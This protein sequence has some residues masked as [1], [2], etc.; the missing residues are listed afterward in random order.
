LPSPATWTQKFALARAM[1]D[2]EKN[3]LEF[4]GNPVSDCQPTTAHASGRV[5]NKPQSILHARF[6]A[7]KRI[8]PIVILL[9]AAIA[10]GV[11]Y[12]PR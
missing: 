2:T 9:A 3:I 10:A 8:I 7:M 11:Y 5:P 6:E 4:M 1:G 12:Y